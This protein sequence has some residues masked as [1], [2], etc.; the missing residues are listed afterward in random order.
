MRPQP[1]LIRQARAAAKAA[2]V[3]LYSAAGIATVRHLLTPY[4]TRVSEPSNG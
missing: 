1:S 2:G 3:P 4:L